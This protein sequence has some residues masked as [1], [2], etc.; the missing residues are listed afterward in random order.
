MSFFISCM[1]L[2]GLMSRPPESNATPLPTSVTLGASARP[3]TKSTR[4]G[5]SALARPTA[6][7]SGRL[8]SSSA[9]PRVTSRLGAEF[10]GEARRLALQRSRPEVVGGRVDEV[11]AERDRRGDALEARGVDALG[12]DRGAAGRALGMVALEAVEPEQERQRRE[13]GLVRRVGE[14]VV[15]LREARSPA[16]GADRIAPLRVL[17]AKPNRTPAR[18]PCG[19]GQHIAG[20]PP[21]ARSRR[22]SAKRAA[23][24]RSPGAV[25][26]NFRR[27][28][29]RR[30]R[31]RKRAERRKRAR[32][33]IPIRFDWRRPIIT[34]PAG[35][36]ESRIS[37][38]TAPLALTIYCFRGSQRPWA[39][40]CRS[41]LISAWRR[42]GSAPS[43][44]SPSPPPA[45]RSAVAAI[46]AT[47]PDR[48]PATQQ[49]L[50]DQRRGACAPTPTIGASDTTAIPARK[51]PRS[52]TRGRCAP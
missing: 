41:S 6:W 48:S 37:A 1:P 42:V 31:R 21:S 11:A 39:P 24:R 46:S 4:R 52:I 36:A 16:P 44:C 43:R 15:A 22:P 18:P 38:L 47:S 32:R 33:G 45:A 19:V 26:P 27:S 20:V 30:E 13:L 29:T 28:R 14:A 51:S 17:S 35:A 50:A 34:A 7:I 49:A 12:R 10:F 25:R 40:S 3:Q 23:P 8:R 9:S 2:D 5:A